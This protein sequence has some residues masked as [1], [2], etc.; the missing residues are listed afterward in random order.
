VTTLRILSASIMV[1]GLLILSGCGASKTVSRV[2]PDE[3]IDLSGE[4][5]DT[6]SRLVADTMIKD[7]M[8]GGW[9]ANFKGEKSRTPVVIVGTVRN[10]TTEH[11]ATTAFIKNLERELINSGRVDFVANKEERQEVRD[12]RQDQQEFSSAETLKKFQQE[13]GADFML[14]GDITSIID[15]EGGQQVKY[16]QVNLELVNIETNKKAWMGEKK[17]KKLVAQSGSKF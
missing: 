15:A 12:E 9:L 2:D 14:R 4:W 5:N 8:V 17:I 16:Y 13:T 10:R 11:I 7:V 1:L 3:Q 6:D